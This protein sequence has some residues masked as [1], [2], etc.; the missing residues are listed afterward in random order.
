MY[1]GTVVDVVCYLLWSRTQ[2]AANW[3]MFMICFATGFGNDFRWVWASI[4]TSFWHPF[5]IKFHVFRYIFKNIFY[6]LICFYRFYQKSVENGTPILL[7]ATTHVRPFPDIA[8][9]ID[10]WWMLVAFWLHCGSILDS[11][12]KT[13]I[14]NS[15]HFI[16]YSE[17]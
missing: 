6:L 1:F 11:H 10:C 5:G 16:K 7:T 2:L 3:I 14:Y 8:F 13:M 15:E 4:M 12:T 17:L 9:Y